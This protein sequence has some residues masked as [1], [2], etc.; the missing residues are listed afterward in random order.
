[1]NKRKT[2]CKNN[3]KTYEINR[4]LVKNNEKSKTLIEK[5]RWICYDNK[6]RIL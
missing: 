5:Q 4:G 3:G 2:Y 1:M 6:N